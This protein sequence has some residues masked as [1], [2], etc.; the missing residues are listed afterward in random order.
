MGKFHGI[1][2]FVTTEETSPG[3]FSESIEERAYTG[4]ILRESFSNETREKINPDFILSNRVSIIG[5]SFAFD[6]IS[7]I[8]YVKWRKNVW[9]VSSCEI[10]ERRVILSIRGVY[11]G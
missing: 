4:D 11:N 10:L 9:E 5:D 3:I 2:G 8:R 7:R 6:N 1:V